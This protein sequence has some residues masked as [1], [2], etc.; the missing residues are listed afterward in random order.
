MYTLN[1]FIF[2]VTNEIIALIN[3]LKS[4]ELSKYSDGI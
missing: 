3:D 2:Y 4:F 1:Y